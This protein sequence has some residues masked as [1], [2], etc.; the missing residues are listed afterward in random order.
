MAVNGI[1]LTGRTAILPTRTRAVKS[2][3][4]ALDGRGRYAVDVT[5][6]PVKMGTV[7]SPLVEACGLGGPRAVPVLAGTEG[8]P[9]SQKTAISFDV[10]P[11]QCATRAEIH[12]RTMSRLVCLPYSFFWRFWLARQASCLPAGVLLL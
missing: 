12:S 2:C 6:P 10:R 8:H 7:G 1:P 11:C 5:V 3:G 4:R 9:P